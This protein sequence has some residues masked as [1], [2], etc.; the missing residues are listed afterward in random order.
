MTTNRLFKWKRIVFA[1]LIQTLPLPNNFRLML[2]LNNSEISLKELQRLRNALHIFIKHVGATIC[3]FSKDPF[4]TIETDGKSG[5]FPV[6]GYIDYSSSNCSFEAT[7]DDQIELFNYIPMTLDH[8]SVSTPTFKEIPIDSLESVL[9]QLNLKSAQ[10]IKL[11]KSKFK[12]KTKKPKPIIIH[13]ECRQENEQ[14]PSITKEKTSKNQ[15]KRMKKKS[16]ELVAHIDENEGV[17]T[18]ETFSKASK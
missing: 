18:S 17:K 9:S 8:I 7:L 3:Q 1:Y 13:G 11:K 12:P 2:L 15:R 16:K 6:A 10:T 4:E 14:C 5:G